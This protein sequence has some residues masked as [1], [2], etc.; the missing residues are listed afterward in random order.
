MSF[1][2]GRL[3]AGFGRMGA[4]RRR[5]SAGV[6]SDIVLPA[7]ASAIYS[8]QRVAGYSGPSLQV[9]QS[10]GAGAAVDVGFASN[11]HIDT[12]AINALTGPLRVS[13]FYDQSGSGNHA[14]QTTNGNRPYLNA[15]GRYRGKQGISHLTNHFL[16]VP[17]GVSLDRQNCTVFDVSA[18]LTWAGPLWSLGSLS[19]D[20]FYPQLVATQNMLSIWNAASA[21]NF[22]QTRF[23]AQAMFSAVVGK[24]ASSSVTTD[25]T[26]QTGT[27]F[28]AGTSAGGFLGKNEPSPASYT[29][30]KFLTAFYPSDKSADIAT[31]RT[32]CNT[33][34]DIFLATKQVLFPGDSITFGTGSTD[35]QAT[36]L[37]NNP[38]Q[39]EALLS[40]RVNVANLG[41]FGQTMA[42]IYTNRIQGTSKYDAALAKN[43]Q[44]I[45][46]GTNDINALASGSIV[47]G[48]TTVWGTGTSGMLGYIQAQKATGWTM[49]VGT[50]TPRTWGGTTTDQ[51]Q[52]ETERLAY[53]Q[54]I[55]DNAAAEGYTVAD[56]ANIAEFSPISTTYFPDNLHPNALGYSKM[57]ALLAPIVEA[58]INP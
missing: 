57:A 46:A 48:A 33:A 15:G 19:T 2:L 37:H 25:N 44:V 53:N 23:R 20:R 11:G 32:A 41:V 52:K 21:Q 35:A 42:T 29:G 28:N 13:V 55:R 51:S 27:A 24:A 12:A 39:T 50:L 26:T 49:V 14:T 5:A 40:E 7:G 16:V 22:N 17:A 30:T 9:V 47:G 1:G 8:T 58:L 56:Y 34:F 45:L 43:I 10:D 31:V 4:I 6:S 36:Y 18:P 38:R 3:G 54:L